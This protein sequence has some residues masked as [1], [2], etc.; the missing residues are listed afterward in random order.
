MKDIEKRA[1]IPTDN[2]DL[3]SSIK[4]E[5]INKIKSFVKEHTLCDPEWTEA[6][7]S[8]NFLI[9]LAF[10]LDMTHDVAFE[11]LLNTFLSSFSPQFSGG[12]KLNKRNI[13][14]IPDENQ[15]L[16]DCM[17]KEDETDSYYKGQLRARN[18][19]NPDKIYQ[20]YLYG[21]MINIATAANSNAL[22]NVFEYCIKE[23]LDENSLD[24]QRGGWIHYRLPWI[25][26]RILLGLHNILK[27]NRVIL[28]NRKLYRDIT[29]QD[30][31]ALDSLIE[32]IY[33]NK[34]WRSGAGDWVSK[35][36]S[37]GLCLEAFI[38]SP[39]WLENK[40]YVDNV[41]KVIDYLFQEEIMKE[42]LPNSIDF[43]SENSTNALLAQTVLSSV[44]YR[45]LKIDIWRKYA[46]HK[47]KIGA[48]LVKCID[49]ICDCSNIH[50]RQYCT[51]P[52]ILLYVAT[53]IKE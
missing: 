47:N 14:I 32:R 35:W 11:D 29:T 40:N 4:K 25:T 16:L 9:D 45:Y 33:D 51:I 8:Q 43:S 50:P 15:K 30:K 36:E 26:A 21:I 19:K 20:N 31:V 39:N 12:F 17:I 22:N 42:W 5:T 49:E 7:S 44:L 13:L 24:S 1:F 28:P 46:V 3:D 27:N 10:A 48:F 23:L 37:T 38:T 52:Q 53:A 6:I 34:Y 41:S 18:I 2:T